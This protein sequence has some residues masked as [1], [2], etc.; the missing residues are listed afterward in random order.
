MEEGV[1]APLI[2]LCEGLAEATVRSQV[3]WTAREETS[4]LYQSASGAVEIRSR[5]RDGEPPFELDVFNSRMEKVDTI[6]SEWSAD[7]EPAAWN[8]ALLDLFRAARRRALGVDKIIDDLLAEVRS[9]AA[10]VQS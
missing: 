9:T 10:T 3:E 1:Y 5:D 4:F 8:Q 7:E 2:R 6:L